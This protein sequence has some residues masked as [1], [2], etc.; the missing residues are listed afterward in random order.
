MKSE[1]QKE[2]TT[3]GDDITFQFKGKRTGNLMTFRRILIKNKLIPFTA[4][5][6]WVKRFF[7]CRA[8]KG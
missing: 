3:T 1:K 2:K 4:N 6:C 7:I 5:L 8:K